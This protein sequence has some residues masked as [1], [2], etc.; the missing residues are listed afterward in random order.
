M[1]AR[2]EKNR[3][4]DISLTISTETSNVDLAECSCLAGRGLYGSCKHIVAI[5]FALEKF[6]TFYEEAKTEDEIYYTWTHSLLKTSV[7]KSK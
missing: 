6:R 3:I 1:L 7:S 4:Y 2:K 5:L